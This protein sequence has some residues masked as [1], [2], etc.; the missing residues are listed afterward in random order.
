[1]SAAKQS[2]AGGE[3]KDAGP[4]PAGEGTGVPRSGAPRGSATLSGEDLSTA[5]NLGLRNNNELTQQLLLDQVDS[6]KSFRREVLQV[7]KAA[8]TTV[9]G[10]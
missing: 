7:D 5:Y 2:D 8:E 10:K 1:M 9:C 3:A 4:S 6:A